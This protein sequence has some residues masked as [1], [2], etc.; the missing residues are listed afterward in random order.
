M[1]SL[2]ERNSSS[3]RVRVHSKL[4]VVSSTPVKPGLVLP[5]SALDHA[6]GRHTVHVV[7]YYRSGSIDFERIRPSLCEL[8]TLYPKVTGRLA[9]DGDGNWEAKCTDAGVRVLRAKVGATLDEWLMSADGEA[10]GDLTAWDEM[11]DDPTT[12][13][14]FRIQIN[15]FDGDG[16]AIGLSCTHLLADPTCATL[17]FKAWTEAHRREAIALPPF[18]HPPA[19]HSQP[20]PTPNT[21]SANYYASKAKLGT[22]PIKMATATFSFSDSQIRQRLS[23]IHANC[24]KASPFDLLTALFWSCILRTKASKHAHQESLSICIDFRKHLHV[25]LPYGYF[26]NAL[27]FSQLTV[28][29][30]VLEDGDLDY[31]VEL[32]HSHVSGLEEEEFLSAVDWLNS[33]KDEKGKFAPPNRMYGP[34]LTCTN[35]EHMIAPGGP[36]GST[37]QPFM[38]MAMFEKDVKPEHV[39]YRIGNAEGE[40]SIL[41]M[42]S[43][44]EGLARRVLVTLPEEQMIKLRKDQVMLSIKPT[45]LLGGR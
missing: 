10:E 25:P 9:R 45:L 14:P 22:T 17:F 31:L 43:P 27:H 11:P 15:E 12:W 2:R 44:E 36:A 29:V 42:P 13:S 28:D 30:E 24:P 8:L 40:G 21:K 16:V 6:M 34:E 41:V 19:L 33:T 4:S 39:S 38:Y 7:F 35:M 32:L 18:I 1:S 20:T 26:G 5:L 37:S 3:S 23:E